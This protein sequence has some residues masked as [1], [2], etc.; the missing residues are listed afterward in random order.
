MQVGVCW[1]GS[2]L[3]H[4]SDV[5]SISHTHSGPSMSR[6]CTPCAIKK[7]RA[8]YYMVLRSIGLGEAETCIARRRLRWRGLPGQYGLAIVSAAASDTLASGQWT[9]ALTSVEEM[10]WQ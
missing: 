3:D 6:A 2:L 1:A 9:A 10:H 7:V 4:Q 8:A 5:A